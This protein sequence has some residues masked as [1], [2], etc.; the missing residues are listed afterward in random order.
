MAGRKKVE[1]EITARLTREGMIDRY[2]TVY[3]KCLSDD[4]KSFDAKG[5]LSALDQISR[6]LGFDVPERAPDTG[7]VILTIAEEVGGRG[8]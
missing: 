7:R 4:P 1:E 2:M 6:M 5:A 8:D 3:E